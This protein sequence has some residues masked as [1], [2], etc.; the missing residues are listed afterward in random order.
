MLLTGVC[1]F[2]LQLQ[3]TLQNKCIDGGKDITASFVASATF[4]RVIMQG[5]PGLSESDTSRV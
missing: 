1:S 5:S 4:V 2:E 3:K